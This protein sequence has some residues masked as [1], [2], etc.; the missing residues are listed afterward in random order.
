MTV[1]WNSLRRISSTAGVAELR[2]GQA[3][4]VALVL[5]GLVMLYLLGLLTR[6]GAPS[7]S[8]PGN[9]LA[10]SHELFGERVKA[11][12]ATYPPVAPALV[13][14]LSLFF[15]PLVSVSILGAATSVLIGIPFFLLV[16]QR[17]GILWALLFTPGVLFLGYSMEMLAWGG[18][19]QLL[20]Q[21]LLLFTLYWLGKGLLENRRLF[22]VLGAASA[23][24]SVGTS[25]FGV[26]FLGV[27]VPLSLLF[28]V[29]QERLHVRKVAL[30]VGVWGALVVGMSLVFLPFYLNTIELQEGRAWNPHGYS[31][32]TS[33]AAFAYVFQEWPD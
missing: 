23:S 11:A 29:T 28:L 6:A 18:Y 24:L 7:G 2:R 5:C 10:F 21:A 31:L 19:P 32:A 25:T 16:H 15:P 14:W 20:S 26:V 22:L 27:A 33:P 13:K 4:F 12:A 30:Q 9:W 1:L 8:D 3:I 17:A